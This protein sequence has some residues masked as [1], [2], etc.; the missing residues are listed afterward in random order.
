MSATPIRDAKAASGKPDSAARQ[1]LKALP[2]A[3]E[4]R[5]ENLIP[6]RRKFRGRA[7]VELE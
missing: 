4:A 3:P 5:F 2:L 1:S 7:P 6:P